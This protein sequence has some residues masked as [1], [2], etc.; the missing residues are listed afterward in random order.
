MEK[1]KEEVLRISEKIG[2]PVELIERHIQMAKDDYFRSN[3]ALPHQTIPTN[4]NYP[5]RRITPEYQNSEYPSVGFRI[6]GYNGII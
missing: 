3:V 4:A 5:E 6:F 2:I 1:I